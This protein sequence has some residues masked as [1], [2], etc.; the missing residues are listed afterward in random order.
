MRWCN[1][2]QLQWCLVISRRVLGSSTTKC[3]VISQRVFGHQPTNV[4]SSAN[5]C[6]VISQRVFGHQPT[7]V[8]SSAHGRS[9]IS[10]N[11]CLVINQRSACTCACMSRT[12]S[13]SP[14][15]TTGRSPP[16]LSCCCPPAR[17]DPPDVSQNN[18]FKQSVESVRE[19][20][21]RRARN[22]QARKRRSLG[23][24]WA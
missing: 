6:L 21:K 7:S 14:H 11:E 24:N 10:T 5:E 17:G 23:I 22:Y 18:E 16:P 13:G 2:L 3:L 20:W 19:L 1:P 12:S 8:R 9:V 15:S 4:W